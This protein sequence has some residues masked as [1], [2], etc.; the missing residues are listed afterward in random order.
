MGMTSIMEEHKKA[1]GRKLL[2]KAATKISA[3]KKECKTQAT[4]VQEKDGK[5]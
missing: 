2:K 3:A 5:V 4:L 1:M